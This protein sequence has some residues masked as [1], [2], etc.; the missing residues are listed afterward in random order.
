MNP[1]DFLPAIYDSHLKFHHRM[2]FGSKTVIARFP[3]LRSLFE[4]LYRGALFE[5]LNQIAKEIQVLNSV[6]EAQFF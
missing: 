4:F 5:I 2:S 1:G 3:R 6:K